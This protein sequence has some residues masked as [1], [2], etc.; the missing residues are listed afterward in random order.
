MKLLLFITIL[1]MIQS[2]A[3]SIA[4]HNTQ[5]KEDFTW[6]QL[7]AL[8]DDFGFAGA[9][10]GV[11]NGVLI[12]IGGA[13]FPDGGAPWTGSKKVWSDQI[14]VL[15]QPDGHWVLAG[16]LPYPL[17]YGVSATWQN[18]LICVG[19]S[20]A[21]GHSSAVLAISYADKKI[22]IEQLPNLPRPLANSSGA[23]NGDELYIAGG[24]FNPDSVT[25]AS[26]FWSLDL[27]AASGNWKELETWP[28]P[29]RM[30]AVTGVQNGSFFL[31]SGTDLHQVSGGGV[32]REYLKDA[33]K[34]TH[35]KGWEKLPSLPHAVVAAPNPAYGGKKD[36]LLIFGGDDGV[37]A[38]KAAE[39]KEHHP[40]FSDQ[41]LSYNTLTNSWAPAG[42]IATNKNADAVQHPNNS[43]WA[44]VTTNFV[45][46]NGTLIFPNG[47][48]RPAVRT[49]RVT[50]AVPNF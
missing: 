40:G 36:E 1:F 11:S 34:Y 12:V 29:A 42:K 26:A 38:P 30:L 7:P 35:Q 43:I 24:L 18:K 31:F 22:K 14:F 10:A 8:P 25:P 5:Q 4:Q 17:G 49:P 15:D 16:K 20:N 2:P 46:W 32:Q 48:V 37:M 44:P 41:I 50:A 6:K 39:L 19:G 45:V 21:E 27:S 13:N 3:A 9:F 23:L 28:G 33:Y 47:E